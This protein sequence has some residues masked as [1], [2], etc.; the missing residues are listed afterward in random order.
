MSE[1]KPRENDRARDMAADAALDPYSRPHV[2]R[3]DHN[4]GL[5]AN[6]A[7]F[8][9]VSYNKFT[10]L[11]TDTTLFPTLFRIQLD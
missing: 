2:P 10:T 1:T 8:S 9:R 6:S 4:R 11:L 5:L 7:N 3:F